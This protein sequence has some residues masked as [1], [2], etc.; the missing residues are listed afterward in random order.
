MT[1]FVYSTAVSGGSIPRYVW[2]IMPS[3]C[4][5]SCLFSFS[6]SMSLPPP[7]VMFFSIAEGVLATSF[8]VLTYST[9]LVVAL[10]VKWSGSWLE[11]RAS[12]LL[13]FLSDHLNV[14]S[15][16]V[17]SGLL[18]SNN[19]TPFYHLPLLSRCNIVGCI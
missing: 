17:R 12:S 13:A 8:C 19:S 18:D 14:R 10:V 7:A 3:I 6:L 15:G 11:K 2:P 5:V 9:V 16:A 4:L 1:R